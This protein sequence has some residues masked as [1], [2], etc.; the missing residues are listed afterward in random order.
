MGWGD[1]CLCV[2]WTAE[3][4]FERQYTKITRPAR[5]RQQ[6]GRYKRGLSDKHIYKHRL[7][8]DSRGVRFTFYGGSG[9]DRRYSTTDIS[10]YKKAVR[11]LRDGELFR[12]YP[13]L[14][15]QKYRRGHN[16]QF[17]GKDALGG[18]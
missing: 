10:R 13:E 17:G 4:V 14:N 12:A 7:A 1:Y 9:R 15:P 5:L 16:R 6:A 8:V 2:A 18:K 3:V 11:E